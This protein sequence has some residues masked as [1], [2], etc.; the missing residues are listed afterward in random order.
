MKPVKLSASFVLSLCAIMVLVFSSFCSAEELKFGRANF[1]DIQKNSKKALGA[2]EEIRKI[3]GEGQAKIEVMKSD[4]KRI[5]EQLQKNDLKPDQ[6]A[7]LQNDLN[8][9]IQ[10]LQTAEQEAGV[11]VALKQKSLQNAMGLQIKA[12]IDKLA[13]DEGYAAIFRT[14]TL[15]YAE[16]LTDLT[17]K[18]TEALD[19]APPLEPK[20]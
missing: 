13:K 20:P 14:D 1:M 4:M 6:K 3:Q 17:G 18:I 12:I 19:A 15:V 2:M 9:K 5:G 11:K 7:K 8:E 10:E 16:G